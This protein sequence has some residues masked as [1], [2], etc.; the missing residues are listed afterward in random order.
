MKNSARINVTMAKR[1]VN[2]RVGW[3]KQWIGGIFRRNGGGTVSNIGSDNG[4]R[5]QRQQ[6]VSNPNINKTTPVAPSIMADS[7]RGTQA[8]IAR[9]KL[10]VTQEDN[11][12]TKRRGLFGKRRTVNIASVIP[13]SQSG[14][15]NSNHLPPNEGGHGGDES[16]STRTLKRGFFK[17]NTNGSINRSVTAPPSS[18]ISSS[19]TSLKSYALVSPPADSTT[20]DPFQSIVTPQPVAPSPSSVGQIQ[21]LHQLQLL[22]PHSPSPSLIKKDITRTKPSSSVSP[23]VQHQSDSP[24][25]STSVSSS[26]SPTTLSAPNPISHHSGRSLVSIN[27]RSFLSGFTHSQKHSVST[28]SSLGK[29]TT[30]VAPISSR[31]LSATIP[32]M[33]ILEDHHDSIDT[34]T[35]SGSGVDEMSESTTL[36]SIATTPKFSSP[37]IPEIVSFAGDSNLTTE[38]HQGFLSTKDGSLDPVISSTEGVER[39]TIN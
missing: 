29:N 38:N 25:S 36:D 37:E 1:A 39:E 14:P 13:V 3:A 10:E 2:Q 31:P 35:P 20:S 30:N 12:Q 9:E 15:G 22:P 8:S 24:P 11:S 7:I 6:P 19:A 17:R 23:P 18:I 32:K 4:M 33:P 5:Q 28:G 16:Q 26:T 27:P 21:A 34:V